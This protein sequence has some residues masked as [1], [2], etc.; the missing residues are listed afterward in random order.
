MTAAFAMH[1]VQLISGALW[2]I[3]VWLFRKAIV[4]AWR[5]APLRADWLVM[6]YPVVGIVQF[7]FS[8]R[9]VLFPAVF[10]LM[11]NAELLFWGGLYTLS[12]LTVWLVVLAFRAW[13]APL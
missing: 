9:W 12:G 3:P 11:A 4:R 10:S 13:N 1:L 5:G 7:G 8:M 6:G 2:L